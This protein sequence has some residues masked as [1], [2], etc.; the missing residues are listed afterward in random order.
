DGAAPTLEGVVG[1]LDDAPTA[2]AASLSMRAE[3]RSRRNGGRSLIIE[4]MSVHFGGV[5]ALDNVSLEVPAG[6]IVGIIGTNG[7]GKTTLFQCIG[8]FVRADSGRVLLG[9]EDISHATPEQ[10]SRRSLGRGFQSARLFPGLT[11]H[12][13][14]CLA[15]ERYQ[16]A[17]LFEVAAGLP[18]AWKDE[19]TTARRADEILARFHLEPFRDKLVGELS[20]GTRRVLELAALSAIDASVILLDEPSTG[21]AQREVEAL[22]PLLASMRDEHGATLVIIEHDVPLVSS[23]ADHLHCMD[24][25]RVISSGRPEEVLNDPLV[26]ASYLGTSKVAVERSGPVGVRH[27]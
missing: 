10:R 20:T 27:E 14:M 18:R 21:I 25:G 15:L 8:G 5:Q 23:V 13:V 19:R 4:G 9:G 22:A 1:I 24:A 26:M 11:P 16:R 17:S 7:A 6:S 2:G 3:P 12:D